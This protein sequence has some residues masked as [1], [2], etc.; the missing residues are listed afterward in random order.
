MMRNLH[1]VE[2]S[3][4]S[5]NYG[6]PC[7]DGQRIITCIH[8]YDNSTRVHDVSQYLSCYCGRARHSLR[9][10]AHYTGVTAHLPLMNHVTS[11]CIRSGTK[12]SLTNITARDLS[13]NGTTPYIVFPRKTSK[14]TISLNFLIEFIFICPIAI[15]YSMGQIIKPVCV[16]VNIAMGH[17]HCRILLID[18]RQNWHGRKNPQ[19]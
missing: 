17:S 13:L 5:S 19:K 2:T 10:L 12:I 7:I 9:T 1:P 4:F 11:F 8:V 18:F 15:A 3:V 16:G 6:A 14:I